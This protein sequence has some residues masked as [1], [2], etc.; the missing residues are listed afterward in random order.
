VSWARSGSPEVHSL[1]FNSQISCSEY[2]GSINFADRTSIRRAPVFFFNSTSPLVSYRVRE[3]EFVKGLPRDLSPIRQL[4]GLQ[5]LKRQ[6][7]EPS[8]T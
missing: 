3:N 4:A 6:R 5:V 2:D 1:F 8:L 7:L